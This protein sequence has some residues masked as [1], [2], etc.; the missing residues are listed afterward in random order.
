MR[1]SL[2]IPAALAFVVSGTAGFV[3]CGDD[4]PAPTDAV[5][6]AQYCVPSGSDPTNCPG[7]SVCVSPTGTCPT[8][9]M[10]EP[11]V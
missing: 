9:C 5:T 11:I 2:R 6:C 1:M 10:P 3:A 4:T 8:G 7:R